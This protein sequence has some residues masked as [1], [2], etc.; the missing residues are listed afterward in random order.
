MIEVH[1]ILQYILFTFKFLFITFAKL[2]VISRFEKLFSFA[3]HENFI[4]WMNSSTATLSAYFIC[5]IW[6]LKCID[7]DAGV[8]QKI[9]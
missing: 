1:R 7:E 2:I 5:K 4:F 8:L 9:E 3:R 6:W